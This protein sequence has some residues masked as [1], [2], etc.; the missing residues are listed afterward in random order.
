MLMLRP[1]RRNSYVLCTKRRSSTVWFCRLCTDRQ[2]SKPNGAGDNCGENA[3]DAHGGEGVNYRP[4]LATR[5]IRRGVLM[6]A[7][8]PISTET[9][10]TPTPYKSRVLVI[11]KEPQLSSSLQ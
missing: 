4:A 3:A 6:A 7:V 1:Q 11:G 9:T 10:L 5:L 8:N 2:S